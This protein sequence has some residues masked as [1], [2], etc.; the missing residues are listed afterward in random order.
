MPSIIPIRNMLAAMLFASFPFQ[1]GM[2]QSDH[3]PL[4]LS[5]TLGFGEVLEAALRNAPEM[6][7]APVRQQQADAFTSAGRSWIAGRPSL[8]LNYYDDAA[9]DNRGQTEAQYGVQL[10]LWRPGERRALAAFGDSYQQQV[11]HWEDALKLDIAGKVRVVLAGIYEAQSMLQVERDATATAQELVRVTTV[12]FDAGAVAKL[13]VLQ[14]ENLLLDQRRREY[15]AEAMLVDA[16]ITYEFMT[17]LVVRPAGQHVEVQS[18]ETEINVTHPVL[19]YLQSDITVADGAIKQGEI[20]ARGNPQLSF[21]TRRERGDRFLPYTDSVNLSLTVPF[22][23]KSWVASHSSTARRA[24]VDAE[25]QYLN[26]QRTLQLAL[27]DAEHELFLTGQ[28]LPLAQ[29]QAA[30]GEQRRTM[31]QVAFEQGEISLAQMLPAVQEARLATRNLTLLN[32]QQQR[33]IT[34]YNQLIG[35]LP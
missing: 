9:L 24:K 4:E 10:P 25:V 7:E 20:A 29:Q 12:L 16:E 27:H 22:G 5:T 28:A 30:L 2:A 32:I 1:E 8:Q 18:A 33:L 13:D 17:G 14:A 11:R 21:G 31:A 19:R 3:R 15:E 23:G 35:V 6:Q 26:T 34:E